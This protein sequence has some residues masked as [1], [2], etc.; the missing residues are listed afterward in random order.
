MIRIDADI[1]DNC[2]NCFCCD[3]VKGECSIKHIIGI[4]ARG[5]YSNMDYRVTLED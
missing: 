3:E 4:N 2:F 1:P 5:G